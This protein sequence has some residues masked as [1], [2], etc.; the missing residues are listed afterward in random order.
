MWK[1]LIGTFEKSELKTIFS[2]VTVCTAVFNI[3][4]IVINILNKNNI[5]Y[6][7]YI[8]EVN[9]V[10]GIIKNS[11]FTCA[12]ISSKIVTK[13]LQKS[14][15]GNYAYG[16]GCKVCGYCGNKSVTYVFDPDTAVIHCNGI[17]RG[18]A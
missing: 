9:A 15:Y 10:S 12:K 1:V 2:V 6:K 17:K 3:F 5:N 16:E 11:F 18:F 4:H 7:L 8:L 14:V 13:S